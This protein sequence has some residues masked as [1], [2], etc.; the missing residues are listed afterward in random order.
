MCFIGNDDVNTTSQ[1]VNGFEGLIDDVYFY[2][3]T[4]AAAEILD[5]AGLSGTH[6]LALEPWRPDPDGDDTVKFDDFDVMA[7]NWLK[8]VFWP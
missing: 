2:G 1:T 3:R 6:N 7:D 8:D 5:L 4:L